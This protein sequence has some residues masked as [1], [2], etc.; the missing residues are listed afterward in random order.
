M[1][2]DVLKLRANEFPWAVRGEAIYLDHASTGPI[3]Q[4]ARD[5]QQEWILTRAEPHRL[6]PEMLFPVFATA[7][8]RIGQLINAPASS[9]ALMTNTSHGLNLAARTLPFGN[10]DVILG[11]HG[12]F[13]ANVY[14]WFAVAKAKG[15]EYRLM[16]MAGDYPDEDAIIHTIE[17]D[18][19]VKVVA[20]SWVS[21]WSGYAI[22]LARIGAACKARGVYFVV[23]GIQ[24]IGPRALDLSAVHVDILSAGCQKWLMSPWGTGFAYVRPGLV[25]E[26]EPVEVGWMSQAT[27]GDF[28]KFLDYDPTWASDARRFEVITL[29]FVSFASMAE[30]IGLFLELGPA[31]VETH[32]SSLA[33]RAVA[34]VDGHPT[35]SLVTPRDAARRAGL[36]AFRTADAHAS[37]ARL[38]AA[39]VAHAVREGCVRIAPHFYNTADELDAAL[40]LL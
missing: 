31:A 39:K 9:I 22:D 1:T 24:G 15:A 18:P 37:S 40:A 7:R 3:P 4:R 14:P 12:E 26:L 29:D 2:Y 11:S 23:D 20:L 5:T 27:A 25:Q 38:A 21:F 30:S 17:T 36:L 33:D 19:R 6:S 34:F 10:G 28:S 32:V 16:P 35:V 13:P 8:E